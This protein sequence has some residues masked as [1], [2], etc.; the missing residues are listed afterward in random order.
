MLTKADLLDS[1]LHECDVS[2]HLA[3]C[4]PADKVN[5]RMTPGQR[6]HIEVMRYLSFCA[7]GGVLYMLDGDFEGYKAWHD[8]HADVTVEQF[9]AAMDAQ[10]DALREAF[11]RITDA[12]LEREIKHPAGHTLSFKRGL[13]E[14]PLKWMVGYRMQLFLC[15]KLAGNADISTSDCWHGRAAEAAS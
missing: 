4:L 5:E 12:D 6:S 11:A 10:K 13:L 9:P 3:T 8:K 15:A 7:I 14:M 2:K 1:I